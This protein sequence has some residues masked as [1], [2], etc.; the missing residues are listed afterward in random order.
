[1]S[2]ASLLAVVCE[3]LEYLRTE[4][5]GNI[6]DPVIRRGSTVL[7]RL[8]VDGDLQRAW[9]ASGRTGQPQITSATLTPTIDAIPLSKLRFA[10]A[11][12]AKHRGMTVWGIT[13]GSYRV[14]PELLARVKQRTVPVA[15][16]PLKTFAEAPA[17]IV[18]GEQIPRRVVI[19]YVANKLGGAH[20]DAKRGDSKEEALFA[21]LDSITTYVREKQAVYYELLS[22]GQAL[23]S[24][25]DLLSL[26][27]SE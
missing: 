26:C 4:W 12:G 13:E 8:V 15:T 16:C 6:E 7:R 11:G 14:T 1:M 5:F 9:K 21:R 19:K 25:P 20:H 22:A 3:D 24:A 27:P 10:A 2:D 17:I 23:A 18:E